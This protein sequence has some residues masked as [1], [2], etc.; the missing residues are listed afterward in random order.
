VTK[1][2]TWELVGSSYH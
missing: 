2:V 1:K